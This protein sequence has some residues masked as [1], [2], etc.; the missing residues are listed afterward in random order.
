MMQPA[1]HQLVAPRADALFHALGDFNRRRM[2]GLLAE[3]PASVS[4]LSAALAI[5]KTAVGQHLAVLEEARL[6]RS[7]KVGR[8]RT[9]Q[10]DPDGLA[11]LQAWIDYHRREWNERL[12]RL[13]DLLRD[14]GPL[15][16][17]P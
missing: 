14:E 13:G 5:S 1:A 17:S 10:F 9:C 7:A 8:V 12:D 3:R 6:A 4:E 2:V 15:G 16:N 11:A